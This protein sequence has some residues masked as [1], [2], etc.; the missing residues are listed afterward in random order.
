MST[1]PGQAHSAHSPFDKLRVSG[2]NGS[3]YYSLAEEPALDTE[4][5]LAIFASG[6]EDA[7]W[8]WTRQNAPGDEEEEEPGPNAP[9]DTEVLTTDA[10][11]N[12]HVWDLVYPGMDRFEDLIMWADMKTGPSAVPGIYRARLAVTFGNE[13]H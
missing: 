12:R 3:F 7:I 5:S 13:N 8:T 1:K 11:L 9:P 10:G 2:S 6:D 4:V